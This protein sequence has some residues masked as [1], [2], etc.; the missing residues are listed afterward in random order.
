M[1]AIEREA[2]IFVFFTA[3]KRTPVPTHNPIHSVPEAISS[4]NNVQYF[5]LKIFHLFST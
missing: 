2:D 4:Q 1:L 3:T 5:C